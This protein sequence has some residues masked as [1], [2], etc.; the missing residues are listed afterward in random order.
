MRTVF[1]AI[2]LIAGLTCSAQ[3]PPCV[4]PEERYVILK[5]KKGNADNGTSFRVAPSEV[6]RVEC[7]LSEFIDWHNNLSWRQRDSLMDATDHRIRS[8]CMRREWRTYFRQYQGNLVDGHK[9]V[10]VNF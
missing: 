7:I 8:D 10:R 5:V 9:V 6:E 2:L 1:V 3:E 4:V